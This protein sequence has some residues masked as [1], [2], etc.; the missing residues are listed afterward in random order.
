MTDGADATSRPRRTTRR[1]SRRPVRARASGVP[2]ASDLA[3]EVTGDTLDDALVEEDPN[4]GERT[5]VDAGDADEAIEGEADTDPRMKAGPPVAV[6]VGDDDRTMPRVPAREAVQAALAA[7]GQYESFDSGRPSRADGDRS[8]P[9]LEREHAPPAQP[10]ARMAAPEPA[11]VVRRAH[12]ISDP[13]PPPSFP[14]PPASGLSP[15]PAPPAPVHAPVPPVHSP[16]PP[17]P[18]SGSAP[19]VPP[20]PRIPAIAA[21]ARSSVPAPSDVALAAPAAL[22]EVASRT[23]DVDV[24]IDEESVP[25]PPT[26]SRVRDDEPTTVLLRDDA[27][28]EVQDVAPPRR[29]G[30]PPPPPDSK[31]KKPPPPPRPSRAEEAQAQLAALQAPAAPVAPAPVPSSP[32]RARQ[33]WERFF[34]DDYLMSVLPP[35]PAQIARQ[36]DFVEQSLALPRGGTVLDVGCGLGLHA[37]E[38]ALRGYLVV[39]L[40]L[41]LPMITRAAEDAQQQ[42]LRINFLH[43]DIREIQFDGAFDGVICL[44]TTF[45]FFDDDA[46]RDVLARLYQALRP[47]GRILIDVVNRDHVVRSQPNLIWFQGDGCVCM[48]ESD[49]NYFTSRLVVKRTMMQED[50]QQ[51]E[52]DY[53]VRLYSLHELGQMMQQMGFRVLEV[54]GQEATR[55]TFFGTQSPRI[56]MLSE[57]RAP[58]RMSAVLGAERRTSEA[59]LPPPKRDG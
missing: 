33:W 57:R 56:L 31:A 53:S 22:S 35:T 45:G 23:D 7:A 9:V 6:G 28:E 20:P 15:P 41:S 12:I 42:N 51:S 16:M 36:V 5:V 24:L 4:T 46:N 29:S 19:R 44:G 3:E 54:S 14:V 38:L 27:L 17:V 8:A 37:R 52:A 13:P 21:V 30:T 59:P 58:Q 18:A 25:P 10:A 2:D 55:G 39:G 43:T 32:A 49:F 34:S 11:V 26:A 47:G 50:G 1:L 48:E 40:D